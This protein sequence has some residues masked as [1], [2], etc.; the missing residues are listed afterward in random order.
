MYDLALSCAGFHI[1]TFHSID[2]Q[3]ELSYIN[4]SL[5]YVQ[6]EPLNITIYNLKDFLQF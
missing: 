2:V 3:C 1:L 4:I 5:Y 6:Q